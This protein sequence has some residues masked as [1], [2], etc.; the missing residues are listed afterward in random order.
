MEPYYIFLA[1]RKK[2]KCS[3][4]KSGL[5]KYNSIY[6]IYIKALKKQ[7]NYDKFKYLEKK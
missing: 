6:L 5:K 7:K 1:G 3:C 4:N 2:W